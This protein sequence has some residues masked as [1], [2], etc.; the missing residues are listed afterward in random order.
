LKKLAPTEQGAKKSKIDMFKTDQP[1]HASCFYG[2]MLQSIQRKK[3]TEVD[4]VNGEIVAIAQSYGLEAPL[5][6]KMVQLVHQVEK[7]GIFIP[8]NEFVALMR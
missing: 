5:N 1:D 3:K 7:S 4:Y 2:S 6:L 8:K